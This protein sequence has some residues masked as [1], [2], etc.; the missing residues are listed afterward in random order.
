MVAQSCPVCRQLNPTENAYCGACG[1][2]FSS[3]P[4]AISTPSPLRLN[5][6]LPPEQ[7]KRIAATLAIS[8]AALLVEAGLKYLQGRLD[9]MPAPRLRRPTAKALVPAQTQQQ[10]EQQ[11]GRT[12]TILSERV[13]EEKRWGRPSRRIIERFAWRGEDKRT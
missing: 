6:T 12:I 5:N 8:F 2:A 7:V 3:S 13:T 4:L 11:H 9:E 1:A 10:E